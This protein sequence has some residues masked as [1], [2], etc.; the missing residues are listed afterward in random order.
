MEQLFCI[1]FNPQAGLL[2]FAILYF[3][4]QDMIKLATNNNRYAKTKNKN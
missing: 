4:V 1:L 2:Y 3:I